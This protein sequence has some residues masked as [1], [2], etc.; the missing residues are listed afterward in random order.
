[1]SGSQ[2]IDS[3]RLDEVIR[4]FTNLFLLSAFREERARQLVKLWKVRVL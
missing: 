4:L 2:V 1:M 3:D